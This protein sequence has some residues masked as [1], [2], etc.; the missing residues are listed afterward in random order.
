MPMRS[1]KNIA[2]TPMAIRR[3]R[4]HK[5]AVDDAILDIRGL[6]KRFKGGVTALD[7][8]DLQIRK[9]EIFAL[10]GPNGAG[11]TTL[12]G[13]VCGLLRPTD[14]PIEAFGLAA[15]HHWGQVRRRN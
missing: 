1:R 12:I 8:V 3:C 6:T 7:H 14:G 10:L 4:S 9:G 11:K 2:S 15:Q 13:A 5:P